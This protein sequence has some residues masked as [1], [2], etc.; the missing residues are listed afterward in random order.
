MLD[1]DLLEVPIH[2]HLVGGAGSAL[3]VDVMLNVDVSV[4][5]FTKIV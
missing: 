5:L 3:K 4:S 2:V 1:A